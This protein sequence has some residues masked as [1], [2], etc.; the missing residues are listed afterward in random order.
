M[1]DAPHATSWSDL[2]CSYVIDIKLCLL[3]YQ[4]V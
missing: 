1:V 2:V 3:M 4:K